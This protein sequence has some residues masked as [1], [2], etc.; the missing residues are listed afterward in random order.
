MR[1]ADADNNSAVSSDEIQDFLVTTG[2]PVFLRNALTPD[3]IEV[4]DTNRNGQLERQGKDV[5]WPI[6]I[7]HMYINYNCVCYLQNNLFYR[8]IWFC[9]ETRKQL[10]TANVKTHG[11][12]CFPD[13]S[14]WLTADIYRCIDS[15]IFVKLEAFYK[16]I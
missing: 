14:C 6:V 2:I 15:L 13:R 12:L 7:V 8:E 4:A 3:A 9:T 1:M 11:V 16:Q 5:E 10:F